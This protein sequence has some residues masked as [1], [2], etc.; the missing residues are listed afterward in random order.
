LGDQGPGDGRPVDQGPGDLEPGDL[1]LGDLG[2]GDSGRSTETDGRGMSAET[3]AK[4]GNDGQCRDP[5]PHPPP[6]P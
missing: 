3:G 6:A 4:P 2:P 1:G 5:N